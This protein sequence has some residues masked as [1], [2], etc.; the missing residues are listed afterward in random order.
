MQAYCHFRLG[1]F[2]EALAALQGCGE[3]RAVARMQLEAQLYYRMGRAGDAIRTYHQLFKE[4]KARRAL[5]SC[6]PS[7]SDLFCCTDSFIDLL[8]AGA[9]YGACSLISVAMQACAAPV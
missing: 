3:D 9:G 2:P 8:K 4:H 1:A 5:A 7:A 6:N